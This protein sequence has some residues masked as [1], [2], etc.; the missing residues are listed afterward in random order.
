MSFIENSLGFNM[1][2][3]NTRIKNVWTQHLKPYNVTPEQCA[4]LF[5]LWEK[6]GVTPKDLSFLVSK[7]APTTVRILGRLMQKGLIRREADPVD[8]R[9]YRIH[10]TD[11]GN[12][13]Q[14]DI[15]IASEVAV[16]K[17]LK[18]ITQKDKRLLM[19]LLRQIYDNLQDE[20]I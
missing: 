4:V 20:D 7:D 2:R 8:K 12:A 11:K 9:S 5:C 16:K 3:T 13:L 1:N 14:D 6:D 10:L 15:A 17:I 18:E 19:K